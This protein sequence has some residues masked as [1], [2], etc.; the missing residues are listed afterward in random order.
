MVAG[1]RLY[2][3]DS[4]ER[5]SGEPERLGMNRG[6]SHATDKEADLTKAV[7]AAETPRRS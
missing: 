4:G 3:K 2:G 5:G 1:L 6:V 7:G